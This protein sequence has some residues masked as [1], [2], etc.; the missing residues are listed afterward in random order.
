MFGFESQFNSG[1]ENEML[2]ASELAARGTRRRLRV[3]LLVFL[4]L[5]LA[6]LAYTFARAPEYRAQA[7]IAVKT[8]G[9]VTG[10]PPSVHG[11][12]GNYLFHVES[13]T[14]VMM[15]DPKWLRVPTI[16][17]ALNRAGKR[18]D[19]CLDKYVSRLAASIFF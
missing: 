13:G 3:F 16:L 14:E 11:I 7:R 18:T 9:I 6:G 1:R 4:P 10:V 15:N 17:A 2:A 5:V 12:C 8:A 19:T